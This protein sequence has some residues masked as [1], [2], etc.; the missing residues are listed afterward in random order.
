MINFNDIG[1]WHFVSELD[2]IEATSIGNVEVRITAADG[3][4][5]L[6][7]TYI[8]VDGVV[9]VYHLHKLFSPLIIMEVS[10][11]FTITVGDVSK[12]VHVVQSRIA[13]TETAADFLPSFFLTTVMTERDTAL[14]R[15][16]L[17]TLL[18]IEATV[19]DV[20]AVA[21][22]WNGT[23]VV[24]ASHTLASGLTTGA[25]TEVD[26]SAARLA[27][28]TMGTLVGYTVTCGERR[29]AYRVRKLPTAEVAMLMRNAFGAWEAVYF[30]GM[31]ERAPEYTR[32]TAPV[33]GSLRL[34]NL[35]ETDMMKCWTGPLRPSGV[36][37]TRDLARSRDVVLLEH[38]V[39]IDEVVVTA[40]EVKH[41]TADSDISDM[42]VTWRRSSL[43]SARLVPV[44]TPKLFDDTFDETYN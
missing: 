29:A 34:Y 7:G 14:G 5:L 30:C 43:V 15:K 10:A 38:G 39:A 3:A 6:S 17:L 20:V 28:T 16:E 44:R 23:K 8:P 21:L 19:P 25:V 13:V 22:Y 32:E 2:V 24:T 42:T 31:T 40:V 11:T 26:V 18:P 9:R 37:L 33:N 12:T 36:A 4:V 27:D 1:S 35:E 41:T